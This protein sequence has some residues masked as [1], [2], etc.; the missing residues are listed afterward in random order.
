MLAYSTATSCHWHGNKYLDVFF[1]LF[2]LVYIIEKS[3]VRVRVRACAC[4]CVCVRAAT[5]FARGG[6]ALHSYIGTCR[7]L[8]ELL[9]LE[10]ALQVTEL[11]E[12]NHN[13]N[14]GL[15]KRPPQNL[16]VCALANLPERGFPGPLVR[17]LVC[18][19]LH[20]R[21]ELV[22]PGLDLGELLFLGHLFIVDR[23]LPNTKVQIDSHQLAA[24]PARGGVR[25]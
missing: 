12:G 3:C 23:L 16:D 2:L 13:Q 24:K 10:E 22:K 18:N 4:V 11:H 6:Y 1:F 7:D 5:Q 19:L 20:L 9:C 21:N 14:K 25:R 17:L 8:D 15:C